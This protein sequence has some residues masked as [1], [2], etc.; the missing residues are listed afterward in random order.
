MMRGELRKELEVA[1]NKLMEG[2]KGRGVNHADTTYRNKRDG[3]N[4]HDERPGGH[5]GMLLVRIADGLV[6]AEE[7]SPDHD[8]SHSRQLQRES[9]ATEDYE[10]D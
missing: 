7:A 4:T 3:E 10:H 1:E 8:A 9:E 6:V 5:G 2:G